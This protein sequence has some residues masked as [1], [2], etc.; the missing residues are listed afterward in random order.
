[1]LVASHDL[2]LISR[3]GQRMLTLKQGCL[4]AEQ[5]AR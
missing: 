4:V 3:L 5:G 2:A 1:V